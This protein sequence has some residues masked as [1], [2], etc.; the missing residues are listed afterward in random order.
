M[1]ADP[2]QVDTRGDWYLLGKGHED[3]NCA[4]EADVVQSDMS[5]THDDNGNID[6]EAVERAG[7]C[8]DLRKRPLKRG[9]RCHQK[10]KK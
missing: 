3:R 2:D 1:G 7:H 6:D 4:K 10:K 8:Y 5:D 9:R